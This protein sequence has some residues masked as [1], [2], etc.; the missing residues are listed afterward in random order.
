MR[1]IAKKYQVFISS[2]YEDLKEERDA[3]IKTILTLNHIPIGMETFNAG[4]DE[5]WKV[6]ERTIDSSDYYVLIL[7]LRYGSTTDDGISYTEKEYDYAVS[8]KI[9]IITLLRDESA[10][11]TPFQRE[12]DV[13][14]MVKLK[15]FR[16]KV[17]HKMAK[18][19]KSTH[20]L[21][22][23]LSTAL[24]SEIREHPGVGW[25]KTEYPPELIKNLF[26][27]KISYIFR[28]RAEKNQ[29]SDPR[30]MIP[31][32]KE[33]DGI[34]FGLKTFRDAH[35]ADIE[36]CL[37]NGIRIRLLIM[38]PELPFVKQRELEEKEVEGQISA[39]ISHLLTWAKELKK[40]TKGN[41]SIKY[42]NSMT[43]DFYWRIDDVLYVGPYLFGRASQ[44]TLTYKYEKGGL[45]YK[46]YTE[47]FE[48]LWDDKSL[49]RK[50]L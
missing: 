20:E 39:S 44:A 50:V 49:T 27:W 38:D 6:I 46:E 32:V 2:T 13:N 17:S 21:T 42:Y 47:Y 5:Q 16:E 23:H 7:G 4:D 36:N 34:A 14:K 9:P 1:E 40:K 35:T 12:N 22:T 30:L 11:S 45:G 37:N 10:P 18:F 25:I 8:K 15:E 19:W 48:S 3:V 41:I 28:L 33:L 24:T 31:G 29:D 26:E 43:L